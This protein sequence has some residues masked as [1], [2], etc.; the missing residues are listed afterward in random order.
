MCA[1]AACARVSQELCLCVFLVFSPATPGISLQ[2]FLDP[3][4]DLP[5]SAHD[6]DARVHSAS[7]RIRRTPS[8]RIICSHGIRVFTHRR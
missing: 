1:H 8:M 5:V 3:S 4:F 2:A 6:A 7:A